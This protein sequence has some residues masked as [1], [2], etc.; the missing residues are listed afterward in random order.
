MSDQPSQ[1]PPPSADPEQADKYLNQL[2]DLISTDKL[3]VSHTDL[4]KFDPTSLQNHYRLDLKD[5][6]IEVSHTKQADSGQDFYIIL[7]NNLK[8]VNQQCTGKIIL[9]YTHLSEEQFKQF[10]AT[11]DEQ[12]DRKR[13]EEERKRFKEAMAPIDKALDQLT[14]F[15][16]STP[17]SFAAS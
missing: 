7:F 12:L 8:Y 14:S 13:K 10:K 4:A 17:P 15:T 3:S 1:L 6:E 5:Y 9:A 11:A 16:N 2:I